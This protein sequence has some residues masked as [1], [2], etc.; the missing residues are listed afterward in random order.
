MKAHNEQ[1]LQEKN[2]LQEEVQGNAS[3]VANLSAQ[4][5]L[6]NSQ[7]DKDDSLRHQA[8]EVAKKAQADMN[9]AKAVAKQLSGT[10]P[11][12]LEQERLAH[13]QEEAENAMRAQAQTQAKQQIDR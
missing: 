8:E 4:V 2:E 6:A 9:A 1:L 11:R 3:K 10:V 5:A 7:V 12:L 13:E